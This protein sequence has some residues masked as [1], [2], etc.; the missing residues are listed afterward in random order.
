[1]DPIERVNA[2]LNFKQPDRLPQCNFFSDGFIETH[3]GL[4]RNLY[5]EHGYELVPLFA[6]ISPSLYWQSIGEETDTDGTF[7]DGWGRTCRKTPSSGFIEVLEYSMNTLETLPR[8]DFDPYDLPERYERV[9]PG[10]LHHP[11]PFAE[12]LEELK[13]KAFLVGNVYDPFETLARVIGLK[14]A[15]M[16]MKSE[17]DKLKPV[18]N[19][20]GTVMKE[21]GLAQIRYGGGGK[22]QGIWIWGDIAYTRG[23]MMAPELYRELVLPA[24]KN[25]CSAFK[26]EGVWVIYHTDGNPSEILGDLID[27][28]VSALHTVE[29]VQG[30]ELDTLIESYSNK[31]AFIGGIPPIKTGDAD[32]LTTLK[33]TLSRMVKLGSS[34]GLIPGFTNFIHSNFDPEL[35]KAIT[36][37]FEE[38]NY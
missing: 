5:V 34:G 24:L 11:K 26:D 12:E 21:F 17:P 9:S 30:M 25:M 10:N 32:P 19:K 35:L 15:L 7:I 18:L 14:N 31:L 3:G 6:N 29:Q 37:F 13:G 28:G 33:P 16:T 8:Y 27:A 38:K 1:M 2:V 23:L 4:E 36:K 20:F 22:L